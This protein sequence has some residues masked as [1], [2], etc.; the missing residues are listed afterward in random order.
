MPFTINDLNQIVEFLCVL[1][2]KK[3]NGFYYQSISIFGLFCLILVLLD[4]RFLLIPI[5]ILALIGVSTSVLVT[6]IFW[7]FYKRELGVVWAFIHNLTMGMIIIYFFIL[8][9][10]LL[11]MKSP[12]L[13]DYYVYKIELKQLFNRKSHQSLLAPYVTVK[14]EGIERRLRI[15]SDYYSSV[16]KHRQVSIE[17]K[18]G[19]W[20]YPIIKKIKP[21]SNRK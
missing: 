11:S 19:F 13:D 6:I 7:K 16:K 1:K 15:D 20:N 10:D 2:T 17:V 21:S 14:I 9:N 18:Q 5:E 8:T 3:K 12:K 4:Y